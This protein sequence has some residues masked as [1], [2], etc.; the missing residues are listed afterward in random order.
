M[1]PLQERQLLQMNRDSLEKRIQQYYNETKNED[2]VIEY[3]LV[4]LV[5]N[6]MVMD[7]YSFI[8]KDLICKIFLEGKPNNTKRDF[9][10][11]FYDYFEY[12]EWEIVRNRLFKNR[13]E[14]SEWTRGI[15]PETKCFRAAAAP[16]YDK[17]DEILSYATQN[18]PEEQRAAAFADKE[19]YDFCY[20]A[21]FADANGKKHM[22]TFKHADI[23]KSGAE[24]YIL[25]EMLTKLTIFEK[26]GVRRF[27]EIMADDC[28][29]VTI[30]SLIRSKKRAHSR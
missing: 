13:A 8:C 21:Y 9:C 15:R 25:F 12:S 6:A 2:V 19:N 26:D 11:Y 22:V 17:F 23:S 1:Q 16:T 5:R 20:K 10:L 29:E 27:T 14:F 24:L 30:H 4:L 18:Y 28:N 3:G 7:D